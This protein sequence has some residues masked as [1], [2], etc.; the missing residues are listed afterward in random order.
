MAFKDILK[1][2][3]TTF[4]WFYIVFYFLCFIITVPNFFLWGIMA[5]LS[6]IV[7][8]GTMFMVYVVKWTVGDDNETV[9]IVQQ[10]HS[11]QQAAQLETDDGIIIE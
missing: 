1:V 10:Q 8:F 6:I 2:I 7:G 4:G 3:Y 9:D 5:G 11:A